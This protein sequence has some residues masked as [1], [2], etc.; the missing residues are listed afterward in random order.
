MV[1]GGPIT[2]VYGAG[3]NQVRWGGELEGGVQGG[4]HVN[5]VTSLM[6]ENERMGYM[7]AFYCARWATYIGELLLYMYILA[8]NPE[9][10]YNERDFATMERETNCS[11]LAQ[12]TPW[13]QLWSQLQV[14][15]LLRHRRRHQLWAVGRLDQLQMEHRRLVVGGGG[16]TK[17][18][19][20]LYSLK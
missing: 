8:M 5:R 3:G 11:F 19:V 2:E 18:G 7:N 13:F 15:G 17:E 1:T 16:G 9:E 14:A 6:K 10:N 20:K 4:S 12:H